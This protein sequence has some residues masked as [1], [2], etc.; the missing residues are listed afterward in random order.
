MGHTANSFRLQSLENKTVYREN[1]DSGKWVI[2]TTI[3]NIKNEFVTKPI[4]NNN[5]QRS[6]GFMDRDNI[7]SAGHPVDL[8]VRTITGYH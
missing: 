4:K 5:P 3:E 8:A 2:I 1:P 7:Q 6:T